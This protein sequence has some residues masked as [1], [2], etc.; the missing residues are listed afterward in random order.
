[1]R[2]AA[3]ALV[4]AGCGTETA[5]GDDAPVDTA[6]VALLADL[7]LA[8]ARAALAPDSL[9]PSLGDSLRAVARAAHPEADRL[10]TYLDAL[11]RDPALARATYSAVEDWLSDERQ[12]LI[13]Q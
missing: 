1:M 4:I 12:G 6:L 9:R 5:T 7:H 8:D 3:L 2:A 11:A 13:P 10:D